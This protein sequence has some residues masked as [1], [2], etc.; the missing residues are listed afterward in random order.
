MGLVSKPKIADY[1]KTIGPTKTPEFGKIMAR[2][3]FQSIRAFI[4]FADNIT[5][6]KRN[7]DGY[8][9]QFKIRPII[10]LLT[11]KF[12]KYY[13]PSKELSVDEM[14]IAYKGRSFLK[15]YNAKKPSKWGYK[16]FVLVD[17]KNGYCLKWRLYSGKEPEL[18][19][20]ED[21]LKSQQIVTD[22][23][24]DFKEKGHIVYMDCYYTSPHLAVELSE[25]NIGMCGTVNC[26]RKGMPASLKPAQCPLAKGDDPQYVRNGKMIACPWHDV[27]RVT[28]LT[29]AHHYGWVPK[30]I[31]DKKLADGFRTVK[32]PFCVYRYNSFMGGVD[33]LD[34]KSKSYLFPYRSR[35][36]YT[37]IYD[38]LISVVAVNSHILY[39]SATQNKMTRKDF[40]EQIVIDLTEY[41]E[42][43]SPRATNFHFPER[44]GSTQDCHFCSDQSS[45]RKRTKYRCKAC[46]EPLC[47]DPCFAE[48]HMM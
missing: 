14:T 48:F 44:S 2:N 25:G 18:N 38:R 26:N 40:I 36:W 22:L 5:I 45:D 35:K 39:L 32:K 43:P 27:K 17:A 21:V 7:E 6:K 46:M 10:D 30:K 28:M 19:R 41:D 13:M 20:Q 11:T 3:K 33:P 15:Q 8:D 29:T 47:I 23:V 16:A 37:R 9:G 42:V 31:R 12:C 1:W 4:H 24:S 34:Q